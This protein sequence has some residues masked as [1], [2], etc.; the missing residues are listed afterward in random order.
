MKKKG[1]GGKTRGK[2]VTLRNKRKKGLWEKNVSAGKGCYCR[3]KP[4][5]KK[6]SG[7]RL[8][9]REKTP[10]ALPEGGKRELTRAIAKTY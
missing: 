9:I 6:T 1:N 4:T 7:K 8:A 10:P 3:G 2:K 5:E